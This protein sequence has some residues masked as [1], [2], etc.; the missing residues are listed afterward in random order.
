[1]AKHAKK[2]R[3]R[4]AAWLIA[5]AM[6][7]LAGVSVGQLASA[8]SSGWDHHDNPQVDHDHGRDDH[9]RVKPTTTSGAT[10]TTVKPTTTRAGATTTSGATTTTVKPT[11]T[12]GATTTTSGSTARRGHDDHQHTTR[13]DHDER[14]DHDQR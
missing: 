1:M 11:T 12:S 4:T 7:A 5:V 14:G 8:T 9:Q 10:T 2:M 6:M 3:S 13:G